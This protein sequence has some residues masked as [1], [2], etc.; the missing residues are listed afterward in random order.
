MRAD[1]IVQ[2]QLLIAQSIFAMAEQIANST[3]YQLTPVPYAELPSPAEEG[4]IACVS[5][6]RIGAYGVV[7]S[8][9]NRTAIVMYDGAGWVI[10]PTRG[11]G[12]T[13]LGTITWAQLTTPMPGHPI[14][15][16]AL[17]CLVDSNRNGYGQIIT[18]SGPYIVLAFFDGTDWVVH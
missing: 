17:A 12:V 18:G 16:G 14:V 6:A 5:D 13:Q 7:A 1:A 8:G 3:G 4:M 15:Q 9:G 11:V 2:S 10:S